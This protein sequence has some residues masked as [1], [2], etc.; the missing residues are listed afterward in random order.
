MQVIF[1]SILCIDYK[2]YSKFVNQIFKLLLHKTDNDVDFFY[3]YL[4]QL[5]NQTLNQ[6]LAIYL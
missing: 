6:I 2:L 1:S 5:A 3:S 4:V